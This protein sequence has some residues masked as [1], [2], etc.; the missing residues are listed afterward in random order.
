M[1]KENEILKIATISRFLLC[2]NLESFQ[3]HEEKETAH[4]A[5]QCVSRQAA[6]VSISSG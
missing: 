4:I 2:S 5:D 3:G 6:D 1:A